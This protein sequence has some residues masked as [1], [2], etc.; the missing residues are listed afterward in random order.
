MSKSWKKEQC[1]QHGNEQHAYLKIL[2]VYI[3]SLQ[4]ICHTLS[5]LSDYPEDDES[6][7][8][9]KCIT[10]DLKILSSCSSFDHILTAAGIDENHDIYHRAQHFSELLHTL[11]GEVQG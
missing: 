7:L 11:K 1:N 6:K 8:V 5:I 9:D 4:A 2:E 3:Y 10:D